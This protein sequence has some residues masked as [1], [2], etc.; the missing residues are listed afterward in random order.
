MGQ[1]I[2]SASILATMQKLSNA[3]ILAGITFRAL[4]L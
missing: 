1:L 3:E 4:K 2:T